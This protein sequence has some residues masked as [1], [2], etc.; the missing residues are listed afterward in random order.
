MLDPFSFLQIHEKEYINRLHLKTY[1]N[2]VCTH[3]YNIL[4]FQIALTR[5]P[6]NDQLDL[7]SGDRFEPVLPI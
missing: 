6:R 7:I 3:I 5:G 4:L 2:I 1:P